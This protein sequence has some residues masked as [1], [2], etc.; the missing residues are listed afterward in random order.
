MLVSSLISGLPAICT[1]IPYPAGY[2]TSWVFVQISQIH[3]D[4]RPTGYL[5]RYPVSSRISGLPDICPDIRNPAVFPAY[6]ITVQISGNELMF[7]QISDKNTD[8][9]TDIRIWSNFCQHNWY[10]AEYQIK[11]QLLP[12][13]RLVDIRN[14]A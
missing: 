13:I 11:C 3:P 14:Q 10:R 6:W 2:P 5:Y 1:N 4:I 7:V 12:D 8:I 9:C